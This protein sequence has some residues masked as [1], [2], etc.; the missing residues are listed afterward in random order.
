ME[1][2][3]VLQKEIQHLHI[4]CQDFFY[5]FLFQ[6]IYVQHEL[7]TSTFSKTKGEGTG[8]TI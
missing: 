4:S 5:F 6:S 3:R 2:N 8:F 7:H 1:H